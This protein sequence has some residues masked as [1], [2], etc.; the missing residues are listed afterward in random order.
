MQAGKAANAGRSGGAT[1]TFLGAHRPRIGRLH[2]LVARL[3][4]HQ[5]HEPKAE[6]KQPCQILL[7]FALEVSPMNMPAM[8]RWPVKE[9][10][11]ELSH[12]CHFTA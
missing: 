12:W 9:N 3:H 10:L 4:R 7:E 2:V 8:P 1:G 11:S 6:G 5:A